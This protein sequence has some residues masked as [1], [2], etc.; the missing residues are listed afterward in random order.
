MPDGQGEDEGETDRLGTDRHRPAA[1]LRDQLLDMEAGE[2][3]GAA[4]RTSY[5]STAR[6][7]Y[8]GRTLESIKTLAQKVTARPGTLAILAIADACQIVVARSK[9]LPGSCNDAVKKAISGFGGKGGGRP[10][11]AQAGGFSPESL[12]SWM[13]AVESYF[14]AIG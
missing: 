4:V 10:D 14:L 7:I 9:D 3:F 13:D 8:N 2:L 6:R 5:A 11:L 1:E 12:N